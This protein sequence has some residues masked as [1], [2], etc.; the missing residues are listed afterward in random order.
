M[1]VEASYR[2]AA[3]SYGTCSP[4][5]CGF[6]DMICLLHVGFSVL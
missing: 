5:A 3:Q 1:A 4:A 2:D 6:L